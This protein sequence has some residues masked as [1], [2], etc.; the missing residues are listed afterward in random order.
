MTTGGIT[1]Q[2]SVRLSPDGRRWRRPLGATV[3]PVRRLIRTLFLGL[4]GFGAGVAIFDR[5]VM[6]WVVQ[7]G[8]E[9]E[10]PTVVG[11]DLN[12]ATK[13]LSAVDLVA[14]Q[15]EGRY[16]TE[17]PR[18]N[19]MHSLPPSGLRVKDGR[20]VVLIP[21]LGVEDRRVPDVLGA[22]LRMSRMQLQELGFQ[23][24]RVEYAISDEIP[25]D[26][27]L[28]MAPS[29]GAFDAG[30]G[31]SLLLSKPR[32]ETNYWL[33]DLRGNSVGE[34]VDWLRQ[35]GFRVDVD[36]GMGASEIALV[37]GQSP[38]PGSMIAAGALIQLSTFI[39]PEEMDR[40]DPFGE[41]GR[42]P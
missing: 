7:Q 36:Q 1:P 14:Q 21:S 25:P 20:S 17:V 24:G 35:W 13:R 8:R 22:T 15:G 19:V 18:G 37:E 26:R 3:A 10:I 40:L 5:V 16:S 33:P 28:A 12:E 4:L 38:G 9:V 34:A 30:S 23:V 32:P 42:A 39:L 11:L 27:V 2:R 29:A 31:V 41:E 6:P